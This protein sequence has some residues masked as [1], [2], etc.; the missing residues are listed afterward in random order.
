MCVIGNTIKRFFY[1]SF[2]L[3]KFPSYYSSRHFFQAILCDEA[4][5]LHCH[6]FFL[7]DESISIV[8]TIDYMSGRNLRTVVITE[9]L[10]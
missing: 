3:W 6:Y 7:C 5:Q 2:E 10:N 4:T 1:L 8:V 9:S